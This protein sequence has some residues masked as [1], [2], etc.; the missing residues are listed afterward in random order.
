MASTYG[1]CTCNPEKRPKSQMQSRELGASL[2]LP[3][4]TRARAGLVRLSVLQHELIHSS[5]RK[6]KISQSQGLANTKIYRWLESQ[7]S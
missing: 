7:Q 2:A 6:T 4:Q 5:C 1:K 3:G